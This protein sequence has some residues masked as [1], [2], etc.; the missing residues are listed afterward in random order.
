MNE[1]LAKKVDLLLESLIDL[2]S[3]TRYPI[4]HADAIEIKTDLSSDEIYDIFEII[5]KIEFL[6]LPIA[7]LG[8]RE[9]PGVG[10]FQYIRANYNTENFLTEQG[11]IKYFKEI[12]D[13]Q[14]KAAERIELEEQKLR[15]DIAS[16][17]IT[18]NQYRWNK[19]IA[20]SGF[21]IALLSL[22]LQ[23]FYKHN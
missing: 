12:A 8:I 7:I 14:K 9:I 22:F 5:R 19:W 3:G 13:N 15:N 4:M 6:G 1:N 11:S 23:I 2:N 21:L 20:I 16:F 10:K 18:R 17:K